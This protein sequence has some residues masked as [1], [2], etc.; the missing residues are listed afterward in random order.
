MKKIY[1]ILF[2][3][4]IATPLFSNG[5][6]DT[7]EET[8]RKE[9]V[10]TVFTSILPQKYFVERIGGNRVDVNVL[11]RPGKSPATYEPTPGQVVKL[12]MADLFFTVGVPFE[13]AF[14]GSIRSSL[15]KLNIVDTSIG[16]IKREI[17]DHH[18]DDDDH[19]EEEGHGEGN[20][21]D[22][23]IWMS[24]VLVKVQALS[25]YNALVIEDPKGKEVYTEGYNNFIKDL[26]L[27]HEELKNVLKPLRGNMFFVFHP[28]FGYFADDYGLEQ[29][30]IESGG[31]EPG[32][33]MLEKMIMRAREKNV[34]IIFVQ[35]EF[36]Q[37]SAQLIAKAIDG[38]VVI[39][40]PLHEDYINNLKHIADKVRK[41][42]Y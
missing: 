36:S 25:I 13:E 14:I 4:L 22:P 38:A 2:T 33:A 18:H 23:H 6:Q 37:K 41:A 8:G 16:I 42:F 3:I 20:M 9:D 24:P 10:L 34:K 19:D 31:K 7:A 29:V 30:A 15:P 32:P 35:P 39:L 27:I 11:V 12:S 1:F 21:K 17:T 28:S 40:D 26:D 5:R